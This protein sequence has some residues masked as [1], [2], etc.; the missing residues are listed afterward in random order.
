MTKKRKSGGRSKGKKGVSGTVTCDGCSKQV[1]RDK[2]KKRTRYRSPVDPVIY[3]E[4]RKAGTQIPRSS[5]TA[6][7]CVNCAVHRGLTNIRAKKD[8][9]TTRQSRIF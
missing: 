7:Y 8:R 9:K 4:L 1:P 5:T 3:R 6:Y 2:A